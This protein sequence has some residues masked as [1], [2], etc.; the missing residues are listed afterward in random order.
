MR[1]IVC[2]DTQMFTDSNTPVTV[3]IRGEKADFSYHIP[4]V[5][6]GILLL[7]TQSPNH[8]EVE[9]KLFSRI[10]GELESGGTA[11]RTFPRHTF[12]INPCAIV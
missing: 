4:E 7:C 12:G 9:L 1:P 2:I 5:G 11:I 8:I 10:I 3:V 6:C